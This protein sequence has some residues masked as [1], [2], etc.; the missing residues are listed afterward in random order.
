MLGQRI[1][2]A[3]VLLAL[4]LPALFASVPWPFQALTLVLVAAAGWEWGRL[5]GGSMAASVVLGLVVAGLC[6]LLL[7]SG[8]AVP[9]EGWLAAMVLWLAGGAWLLRGGPSGWSRLAPALRWG[10]GPVILC[11][12]WAAIAQ[13]RAIGINFVLSTLA[14]VWA[15]DITAYLFG[16]LFGRHKLAP[17]ISPGKTWEGAAGGLLGVMLLAWAWTTADG[18][19][20]FDGPSL[21][22]RLLQDLGLAGLLAALALLTALSIVGDLVE[23]LVKRARGVKDSSGLLPGHGGVLDRIDALLPV[24]PAALALL[25]LGGL[26]R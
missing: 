18:A 7:L 6:A 13:S 19:W 5:A 21:Y 26:L 15:A 1:V 8:T 24:C 20:G 14:L 2:T 3:L 16:H 11:L 17:S 9:A 23:S 4:L 25:A 22:T 12:A 10:T